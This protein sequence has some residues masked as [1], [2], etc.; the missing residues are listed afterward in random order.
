MLIFQT[1]IKPIL[2]KYRQQ[3]RYWGRSIMKRTKIILLFCF[4]FA[5]LAPLRV[6]MAET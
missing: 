4:L 2:T 3:L 6:Q 1:Q 5:K